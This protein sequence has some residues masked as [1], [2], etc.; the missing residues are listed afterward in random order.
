[1][2]DYWLREEVWCPLLTS[3]PK[4]LVMFIELI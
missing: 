3:D 2:Q 1:M 4:F